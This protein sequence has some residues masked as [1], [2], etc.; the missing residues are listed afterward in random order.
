MNTFSLVVEFAKFLDRCPVLNEIRRRRL[1][2]KLC[3]RFVVFERRDGPVR[4]ASPTAFRTGARSLGD[5]F[6]RLPNAV[7]D[8]FTESG[9]LKRLWPQGT[10]RSLQIVH[11]TYTVGAELD[12]QMT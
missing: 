1:I 4:Q 10:L 11:R 2:R 5:L 12:T 9:H 6:Q 8:D 7:C 3:R